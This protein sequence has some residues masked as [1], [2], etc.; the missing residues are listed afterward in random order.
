MQS[1][2]LAGLVVVLEPLTGVG[3]LLMPEVS[4]DLPDPSPSSA[5]SMNEA[6]VSS[7]FQ[8]LVSM[9][10]EPHLSPEDEWVSLDDPGR[11]LGLY[12]L[13]PIHSEPILGDME[14]ARLAI[15]LTL[16][17]GAQ[18][19]PSNLRPRHAILRTARRGLVYPLTEGLGAAPRPLNGDRLRR[20]YS[21]LPRIYFNPS[22]P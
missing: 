16:G 14:E 13:E 10:W 1:Y 19:P 20:R 7:A 15:L 21:T 22:I 17:V 12:M 2:N 4:Q 6:M 11:A 3:G 9:G 18:P 8:E 5:L